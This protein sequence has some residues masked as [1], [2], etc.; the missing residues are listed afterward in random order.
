MGLFKKK[1]EKPPAQIFWNWFVKNEHRFKDAV[2]NT[3]KAHVF[4][5]EL[6]T[7]MK[8][9]N[10][11]LKALAGPYDDKR[12]ELI[13]TADGDIALFCK[14][15]ELVQA[16]P[17]LPNWL[18]TAHKP[19]IGMEPMSIE[20][21]GHRFS[22][23]NMSFYPVIDPNYPDEINIV[24]V[25]PDY[26]EDEDGNFQTAGMIYLENALGELNTATMIDKYE[27]S[28]VPPPEEQVELI[29]LAKLDGYLKWREKEFV[30]KYANKDA[31]RPVES[32]GVLEAEDREGKPMFATIDSGFRGWEYMAA[33][34]WLVQVDIDYKG[35]EKGLPDKKQMEQLQQ[36][37]D[38]LVQKLTGMSSVLFLGHHTHDNRRSIFIHT[39]DYYPVSKIIHEYIDNNTSSYKPVFFIRKDKY[40]QNMAFFYDAIEE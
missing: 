3:N 1:Q 8:P 37:E 14:V 5:D 18:I 23:D 36:I 39:D 27:L 9:F 4:L 30:E 19:S 17:A 24:I 6:I 26:T 20:M 15:D 38:D 10:P 31:A 21:F 32:W 13:I 25:H 34:P 40:W 16:A 7:Q 33:Y 29:P 22:T 11:W 2:G 35:S 12:F 28:R